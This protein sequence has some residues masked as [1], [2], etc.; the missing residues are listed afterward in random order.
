M[1]YV[2]TDSTFAGFIANEKAMLSFS[3]PWCA[4]CR[5]VHSHLDTLEQLYT[6]VSFGT[7]DISTS[8]STPAELQ[9]LSIPTVIFFRHGK[10]LNRLSG[11]ISEADLRKELDNLI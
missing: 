6:A 4:A 9:V 8:P 7:I 5:K 10:E 2:V 1:S 3:S 11:N